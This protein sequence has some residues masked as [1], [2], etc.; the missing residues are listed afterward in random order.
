MTTANSHVYLS[1]AGLASYYDIQGNASL[2][3]AEVVF[4]ADAPNQT[5][6]IETNIATINRIWKGHRILFEHVPSG[7]KQVAGVMVNN[8]RIKL[9]TQVSGWDIAGLEEYATNLEMRQEA[10]AKHAQL[11][12]DKL[13]L[14]EWQFFTEPGGVFDAIFQEHFS[15]LKL[16]KKYL[17]QPLLTEKQ[18]VFCDRMRQLIKDVNSLYLGNIREFHA[19]TFQARLASLQEAILSELDQQRKVIISL[20]GNYVIRNP[21]L[22]GEC[23]DLNRLQKFLAKRKYVI[24]N[25]KCSRLKIDNQPR[26]WGDVPLLHPLVVPTLPLCYKLRVG[27]FEAMP[28]TVAYNY[29]NRTRVHPVDQPQLPGIPE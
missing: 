18:R 2:G 26:L 10:Y 16:S 28:G 11:I 7:V 20:S 24:M 5:Q 17:L 29:Q 6:V 22:E 9:V 19:Q 15:P 3:Q 25:P 21:C 23:Y 13:E 14:K 4:V 27:T 8:R 1:S 12:V